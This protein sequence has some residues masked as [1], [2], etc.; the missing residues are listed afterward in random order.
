VA[1]STHSTSLE[2]ITSLSAWQNSVLIGLSNA[3]ELCP[4][5]PKMRRILTSVLQNIVTS[6]FKNSKG[7]FNEV[8]SIS[9]L[10]HLVNALQQGWFWA[11]ESL[12]DAKTPSDAQDSSGSTQPHTCTW[13]AAYP[14]WPSAQSISPITTLRMRTRT[15]RKTTLSLRFVCDFDLIKCWKHTTAVEFT[16]KCVAVDTKTSREWSEKNNN[17]FPSMCTFWSC[18]SSHTALWVC[19]AL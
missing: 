15:L 10:P 19:V 12:T 8:T 16:E 11:R 7:G 17:P 13:A 3:W 2:V 5:P 14:N 1:W 9:N 18:R 4:Q 6:A